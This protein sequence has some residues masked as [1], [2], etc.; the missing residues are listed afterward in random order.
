MN[1]KS[2]VARWSPQGE[3]S[4]YTAGENRD[5]FM[6]LADGSDDIEIDL[7]GVEEIDTAGLQ[8][9]L[10]IKQHTERRSIAVSVTAYSD[11]VQSALELTSLECLFG[12]AV[13]TAAGN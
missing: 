12:S 4:I 7:S 10:M 5:S 1:G 11:A 8:I 9:L 13:V 3:L 6:A 2:G